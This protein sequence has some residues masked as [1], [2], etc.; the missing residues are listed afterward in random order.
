MSPLLVN[1]GG[2]FLMAAVVWWFWLAP[3]NGKESHDNENHH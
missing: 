2:V 1:L 3:S